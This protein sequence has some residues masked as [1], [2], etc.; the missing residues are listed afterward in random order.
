MDKKQTLARWQMEL[1]LEEPD[2][3]EVTLPEAIKGEV[4]EGLARL[5]LEATGVCAPEGEEESDESE[6]LA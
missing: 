6:D 2:S 3:E 1:F 4:V 5:L